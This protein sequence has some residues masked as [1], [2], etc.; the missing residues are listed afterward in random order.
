MI[1]LLHDVQAITSGERVTAYGIDSSGADWETTG[2][3]H[4]TPYGVLI[5][6]LWVLEGS[7]V[8]HGLADIVRHRGQS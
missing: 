3:A 6:C 5:G 7:D 4:V 1:D 2:T 8:T